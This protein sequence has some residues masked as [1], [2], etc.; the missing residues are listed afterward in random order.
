[1]SQSDYIQY[2]KTSTRLKEV[3]KLDPV[4]ESND[5]IEFMQYTLE[6]QIKNTKPLLNQLV[7]PR[8]QMI[9]DMQINNHNCP[10]T[11]FYICKQTNLRENRTLLSSI[12]ETIVPSVNQHP[13]KRVIY[14]NS[15]L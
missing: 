11:N 9:W 15:V 8:K 1:M 13:E 6:N 10:T 14:S 3:F 2:K 4:L 5:Y 7:I 12:P